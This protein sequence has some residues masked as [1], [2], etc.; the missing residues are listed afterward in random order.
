M[1]LEQTGRPAATKVAATS[2]TL[3]FSR[4][5]QIALACAGVGLR[6]AVAPSHPSRFHSAMIEWP[7]GRPAAANL[8][9]T[10]RLLGFSRPSQIALASATV[11]LLIMRAPRARAPGWRACLEARDLQAR[12]VSPAQL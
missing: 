6:L 9:A 7:I 12:P 2:S 8:A 4:L 1:V 10:L 3:G 11:A 5:S